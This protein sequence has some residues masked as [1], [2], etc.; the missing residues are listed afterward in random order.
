M[1]SSVTP[2]RL[3]LL[4]VLLGFRTQCSKRKLRAKRKG[5][6]KP[7]QKSLRR[8]YF[9][10]ILRNQLEHT[11]C[12]AERYKKSN[13]IHIALRWTRYGGVYVVAVKN[14]Y[15]KMFRWIWCECFASLSPPVSVALALAKWIRSRKPMKQGQRTILYK[16]FIKNNA[17]IFLVFQNEHFVDFLSFRLS[18]PFVTLLLLLCGTF[19]Y[20]RTKSLAFA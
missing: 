2:L 8:I 12:V 3:F 6:H 11:V 4:L 18:F 10:H 14:N 16:L 17:E 20:I 7:H 9:P 19:V 1:T 13:E 5:K 15:N